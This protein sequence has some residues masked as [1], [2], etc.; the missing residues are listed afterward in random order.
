VSTPTV[1]G[2]ENSLYGGS[3]TV[4][5]AHVAQSAATIHKVHFNLRYVQQIMRFQLC[6]DSG[7][8]DGGTV[9]ATGRSLFLVG[10]Y[11]MLMNGFHLPPLPHSPGNDDVQASESSKPV[12]VSPED[13][14]R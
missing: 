11:L 6:R 14:L 10:E 8:S 1:P 3:G 2:V 5:L 7:M 9:P 12:P 4:G 13:Q